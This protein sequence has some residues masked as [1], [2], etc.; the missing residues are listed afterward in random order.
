MEWWNVGIVEWCL[1]RKTWNGIRVRDAWCVKRETWNVI[2]LPGAFVHTSDR[3]FELGEPLVD[4]DAEMLDFLGQSQETGVD[5]VADGVELMV[6]LGSR[7]EGVVGPLAR[8]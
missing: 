7:D 2:L 4:R 6:K 5:F 8:K 3:G 1:M